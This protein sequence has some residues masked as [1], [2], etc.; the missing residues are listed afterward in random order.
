M[1]LSQMFRISLPHENKFRMRLITV[2]F[3]KNLINGRFEAW[4]VLIYA[5][6]L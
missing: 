1:H 2:L 3:I 6:S 4:D 5:I